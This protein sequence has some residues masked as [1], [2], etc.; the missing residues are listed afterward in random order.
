MATLIQKDIIINRPP[1]D[2]FAF[3]SN[4]ENDP[5]WRESAKEANYLTGGPQEIGSIVN[6]VAVFM[7]QEV[8]SKTKI[9]TYLPNKKVGF[10]IIEG[11]ISGRAWREVEAFN[12]GTKLTSALEVELGGLFRFAGPLLKRRMQK[13][14][15]AELKDL[16]Q[17]LEG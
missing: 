8:N 17:L 13:Q 1:E 10:D 9:T 4:Y 12:G 6:Y 16:K 15:E 14:S 11:M 5:Q 3:I 7:G 2:V